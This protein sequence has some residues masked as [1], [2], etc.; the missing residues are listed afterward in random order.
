MWKTSVS[1]R[2]EARRQLSDNDPRI[3]LFHT[4]TGVEVMPYMME[5]GEDEIVARRLRQV[6]GGALPD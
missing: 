4:G 5:A 6:F 3:E 2:E 1:R